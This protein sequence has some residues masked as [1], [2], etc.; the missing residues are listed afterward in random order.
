MSTPTQLIG[1]ILYAVVREEDDDSLHIYVTPKDYYET[2]N[3]QADW[4]PE[5]AINELE[6][7]GFIAS[8]AME[9]VIEIS[10]V[11]FNKIVGASKQL[12]GRLKNFLEG[13]SL[14]ERSDALL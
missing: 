1:A 2:T 12:E 8:E 7:V 3:A 5:E 11:S 14:F 6:R 10:D 4:T 13:H 9:G